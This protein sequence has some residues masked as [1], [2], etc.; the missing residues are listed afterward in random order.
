[1][2]VLRRWID[3]Y[4]QDRCHCCKN[5]A[6]EYQ[7]LFVLSYLSTWF[8]WAGKLAGWGS[9]GDLGQRLQ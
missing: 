7:A 5:L 2:Q 4:L 8:S 1:M 6:V 3:R 9:S